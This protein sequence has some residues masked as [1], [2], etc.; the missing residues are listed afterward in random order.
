MKRIDMPS[1]IK[2]SFSNDIIKDFEECNDSNGGK[3][4]PNVS[5]KYHMTFS[6]QSPFHFRYIKLR[7]IN[8]LLED[9][10][11]QLHFIRSISQYLP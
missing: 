10:K 9:R 2:D 8:S 1:F 4:E 11:S 6:I 7:I 5:V 3:K